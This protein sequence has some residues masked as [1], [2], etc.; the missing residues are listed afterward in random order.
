MFGAPKG[1]LQSPRRRVSLHLELPSGALALWVDRAKV[2]GA[3]T[4]GDA[5]W[6]H[7]PGLRLGAQRQGPPSPVL[8]C[9]SEDAAAPAA[10]HS[11]RSL[12]SLGGRGANLG[13]P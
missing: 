12:C 5:P 2:C 1:G 8:E 13:V 7:A 9:S 4:I 10:D 11:F 3:L 6:A